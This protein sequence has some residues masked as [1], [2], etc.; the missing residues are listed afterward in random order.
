MNFKTNIEELDTREIVNSEYINWD[1]FKNST[2]MITGATGLIG[3]QI[4]KSILL[5]N[6]E[7]NTNI[8]ILAL[9]RNKKKA[10]EKFS[11]NKNLKFIIQDISKHVKYNGNVDFIIHTANS[12]S[13]R[14]FVEKPVETID[15]IMTG[16]TNILNFGKSKNI[17]GMVYLSS[18]EVFGKT[19][20]ERV[21][22][23]KEENYG[24]IDILN[25]RSSYPEGKRLAETLCHSYFKEY[26]VPVKIARL[27]QTIGAGVDYN[28]NRVFAQFARNI[29]EKKNIVLM[30]DGTT[31]RNYCYVTDA[32]TAFFVMLEK[33]NNGETY[34]VANENASSS[35][36]NMAEM[37]CENYTDSKLE[38]KI[39]ED[40]AKY[41]LPKLKTIVGTQKLQSLNWQAKVDLK[42]MFNRLIENFKDLTDLNHLKKIQNTPTFLENI[43]YVKNSQSSKIINILGFKI[44]LNIY[45]KFKKFENLNI[46]N[47]KIVFSNFN[48]NLG[49]G[50]NPKYIANEIIK[51]N[52]PYDLVW[53]VNTH[54][55]NIDLKNFPKNIKIVNY[56]STQALKELATAK[57][58]I[59]NQAKLYHV[60][61]GLTKRKNQFFIQTWH[62]SLGIKKIGTD[63]PSNLISNGN[64]I[65][66]KDSQMID[67]LISNSSFEDNVYKGRFWE[68]GKILRFGHCRND[69]FFYPNNIRNNILKFY[70]INPNTK[71]I[72]YAP[73]YRDFRSNKSSSFFNINYTQLL[74]TLEKLTGNSYV[75]LQRMHPNTKKSNNLNNKKIIDVSKYPDM[76]EL[77]VS[78][79]ILISDYSSCMFDFM[80]S[81]KPCFIYA[82]DIKEYNHE[83]GFYY[84]LE[85]TPFPIATNNDE[86]IKN[87]ENF[88]NDKYKI[89]VEE[90]L[91][92]KGCIEDG[93]ASERVVNLIKDLMN[94]Q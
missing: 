38:F 94:E 43:F 84:P 3:E 29:C 77:L 23:L 10:L 9:V 52:L 55:K 81:R 50:C 70:N 89:E 53:L 27:V 74:N 91:K 30:T 76:Q 86:L 60:R 37:L 18:M 20:F 35:I 82:T 41:Y 4:V 54:K 32:I 75:I 62:G 11:K 19:D 44:K 92:E 25:T 33:G 66:I 61:H 26:N 46:Q 90:F 28:D 51:Q 73:T 69:I 14:D 48:G 87:I 7:K 65:M 83:R 22:P 31:E 45:K 47:N 85:S 57:I 12:T 39:S 2:I 80:L 16:T 49:Y 71:L 68:N 58:W 40:G 78:A 5:A 72:L 63:S 36:R 34:N 8:K 6:E 42:E 64:D 13:S 88:D 17:K 1:F 24:Y 59:D 21:E 56:R 79:D 67:Y 15:S 93:H